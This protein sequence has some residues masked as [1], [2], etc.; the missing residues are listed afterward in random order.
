MKTFS[1]ELTTECYVSGE[2]FEALEI[3]LKWDDCYV[4][5]DV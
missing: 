4:Q 3:I 1:L 2:I 5:L